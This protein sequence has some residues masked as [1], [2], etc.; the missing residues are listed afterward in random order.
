MKYILTYLILITPTLGMA[1]LTDCGEYEVR[2]VVRAK[3]ASYETSAKTTAEKNIDPDA[4]EAMLFALL[5]NECIAGN[6]S[7]F[8]EAS[9]A[10]P[11][12]AMGKISFPG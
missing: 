9:A 2:G 12:I 3:K 1:G 10:C 5:A 11:A 7:D 4:K 6:A 8:G